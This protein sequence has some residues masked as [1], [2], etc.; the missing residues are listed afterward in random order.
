MVAFVWGKRDLSTALAL[1]KR[2]IESGIQ[3]T[4]I[5][6]DNWRSFKQAFA[7]FDHLVGKQYTVGIEGNNN[8]L[9]HK[10]ACALRR[11]RCF[12]KRKFFHLKAFDMLFHYVHFGYV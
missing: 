4:Q 7:E 5:A 1:K 11:S 8:Q 10:I 9:R 3:L 6:T 2:L 12:S